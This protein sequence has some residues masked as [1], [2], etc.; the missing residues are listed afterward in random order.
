MFLTGEI[1]AGLGKLRH[2]TVLRLD[3]NRLIGEVHH[4]ACMLVLLLLI[5]LMIY[6]SVMA[7]S[8]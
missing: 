8:F 5:L 1:P 4:Y 7:K 6:T 2:L 3:D